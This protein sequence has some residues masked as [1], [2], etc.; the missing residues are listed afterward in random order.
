MTTRT[1]YDLHADPSQLYGV[2]RRFNTTSFPESNL[3]TSVCTD[4]EG[5]LHSED[6]PAVYY[7]YGEWEWW[8]HG[9]RHRAGGLPARY[10][11]DTW[12]WYEDG[13][14]YAEAGLCSMPYFK[15]PSK[16]NEAFKKFCDEEIYQW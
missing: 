12:Y 7:D 6:Q 2:G 15:G 11:N 1:L 16:Y 10:S 13:V 9:L 3:N 14:R 4:T 8:L 5:R